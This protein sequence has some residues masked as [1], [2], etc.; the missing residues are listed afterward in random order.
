M[1]PKNRS[2]GIF[3]SRADRYNLAETAGLFV[4]PPVA[5]RTGMQAGEAPTDADRADGAP[6]PV[7]PSAGCLVALGVVVLPMSVLFGAVMFR[8]KVQDASG[9]AAARR[10]LGWLLVGMVVAAVTA[11]PKGWAGGRVPLAIG[12]RVTGGGTRLLVVAAA[13]LGPLLVGALAPSVEA[14]VI[15]L[16]TL[17]MTWFTAAVYATLAARIRYGGR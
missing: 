5:E 3:F 11:I 12:R 7:D 8:L 10:A 17:V 2:T 4:Q 9:P 15:G 16:L 14:V 13:T 6:A 1:V